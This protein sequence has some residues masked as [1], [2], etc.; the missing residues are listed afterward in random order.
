MDN[1]THINRSSLSALSEALGLENHNQTLCSASIPKRIDCNINTMQ[2]LCLP[3]L[4]RPTQNPLKANTGMDICLNSHRG[5][6]H[7]QKTV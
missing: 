3:S 7:P 1:I 2:A 4:R 5:G 6:V